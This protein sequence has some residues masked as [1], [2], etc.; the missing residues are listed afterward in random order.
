VFDIPEEG[1]VLVFCKGGVRSKKAIL[2]LIEGGVEEK[3]LFSLD[4]GILK[5][6]MDVDNKLVRY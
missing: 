1:D 6:Q 4:G 5:W 3:R 2:S